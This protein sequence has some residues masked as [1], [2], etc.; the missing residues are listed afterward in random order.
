MRNIPKVTAIILLTFVAG[1][2]LL[3][4]KKKEGTK[5]VVLQ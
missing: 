1:A 2:L 5:L 4:N 3:N